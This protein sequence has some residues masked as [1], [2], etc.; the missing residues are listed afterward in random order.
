MLVLEMEQGKTE[1]LD[2][3]T[4]VRVAEVV[5]VLLELLA[6]QQLAVLVEMVFKIQ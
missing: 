1:A 2:L 5:L 4:L 6:H 3:A